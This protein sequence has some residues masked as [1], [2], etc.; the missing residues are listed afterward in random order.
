MYGDKVAGVIGLELKGKSTEIKHLCVHPDFRNKGIG[1]KL[2]QKAMSY[3][4]TDIVYGCVRSD[5]LVNIRNNI[6]IG[7]MPICKHKGRNGRTILIFAR[8][9]RWSSTK[10]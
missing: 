4:T 8:R 2:L 3:A 1:L 7:M 9:I 6:R 5:N 10:A